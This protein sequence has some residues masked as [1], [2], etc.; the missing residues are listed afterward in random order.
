M[1]PETNISVMIWEERDEYVCRLLELE[2]VGRCWCESEEKVLREYY[3]EA[4][5]AYNSWGY[6]LQE[7]SFTKAMLSDV[8]SMGGVPWWLVTVVTRVS[9]KLDDK[10]M[11]RIYRSLANEKIKDDD[12]VVCDKVVSDVPCIFR[13][14]ANERIF[15]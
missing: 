8:M 3:M 12:E 6:E 9:R 11:P 10:D 5:E 1:N 4:Y 15:D 13:T 7:G 14:L 2:F